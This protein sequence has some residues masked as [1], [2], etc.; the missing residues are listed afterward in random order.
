MEVTDYPYHLRALE[1]THMLRLGRIESFRVCRER[2][3]TIHLLFHFEGSGL[4]QSF[5]GH[6]LSDWDSV[7]NREKGS[8]CGMDYML[9]LLDIFRVNE[10]NDIVGKMA[11]AIYK[12]PHSYNDSIV[13]VAP[14][15]FDH[16][17]NQP[18][19]LIDDW[20]DQWGLKKGDED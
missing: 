17:K 10:L 2:R 19:F 5:G 4:H 11:Y 9:R 13:G 6:V 15:Y 1:E 7:N 14:L 16:V 3:Y 20:C 8:A 12:N 18:H